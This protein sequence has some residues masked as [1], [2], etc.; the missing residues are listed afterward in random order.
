MR[1]RER[2]RDWEE[3]ERVQ[4]KE[5]VQ[6]REIPKVRKN[7]ITEMINNLFP[8][9]RS[10]KGAQRFEKRVSPPC[11]VF[12]EASGKPKRFFLCLV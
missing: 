9:W 6:K 7:E 3:T 12:N 4:A 5:R 10:Q 1:E 2:E 8:R 11:I